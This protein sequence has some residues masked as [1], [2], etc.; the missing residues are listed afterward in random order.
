MLNVFTDLKDF[1]LG[2]DDFGIFGGQDI[3]IYV[4][5]ES[6]SALSLMEAFR[7]CRYNPLRTYYYIPK[8]ESNFS[9]YATESISRGTVNVF[10]DLE[11]MKEA[12]QGE[13]EAY[14]SYSVPDCIKKTAENFKVMLSR[15]S[16][17]SLSVRVSSALNHHSCYTV[18]QALLDLFHSG[19]MLAPAEFDS[20]MQQ[21]IENNKN[22]A[23]A[24]QV[25]KEYESQFLSVLAAGKK[26]VDP[27]RRT[28]E[29]DSMT[30]HVML[31]P[32][33]PEIKSVDSRVKMAAQLRK[34]K[35]K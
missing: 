34:E 25:W 26:T 15:D 16:A 20:C 1:D 24:E 35:R 33:A 2:V 5:E 6:M 28:E 9:K 27:A 29:Y 19:K 21:V 3:N 4:L 14:R 22:A 10:A 8:T 7:A 18:A 23:S 31:Q 30:L 12:L 32:F 11:E 17:T 13:V